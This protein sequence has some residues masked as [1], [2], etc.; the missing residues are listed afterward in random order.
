M[1]KPLDARD[2]NPNKK[3]E[4]QKLPSDGIVSQA[5]DE[6]GFGGLA[7][8]VVEKLSLPERQRETATT[9]VKNILRSEL[10][11][12]RFH[13]GPLPA[14]QTLAEYNHVVPNGAERIMTMAE[15]QARHRQGMERT[16]VRAAD[17]QSKWGM[18]LGMATVFLGL[19]C[20]TWTALAGCPWQVPVGICSIALGSVATAFILGQRSRNKT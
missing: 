16:C 13:S 4:V 18:I 8:K 9:T 12:T 2:E 3:R 7:E 5:S 20:A 14:P 17:R 1:K 6:E 19:S 15:E 10:S 11:V